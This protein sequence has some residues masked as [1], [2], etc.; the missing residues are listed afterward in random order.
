MPYDNTGRFFPSE[1]N[2]G[3]NGHFLG[4]QYTWGVPSDE[5]PSGYSRG[6]GGTPVAVLTM[7][8]ILGWP[9]VFLGGFFYFAFEFYRT[10]FT[11][12]FMFAS[13]LLR[14]IIVV[15]LGLYWFAR[16]TRSA[17][18]VKVFTFLFRVALLALAC[19]AAF[20]VLRLCAAHGLV[21]L[22]AWAVAGGGIDKWMGGR[23]RALMSMWPGIHYHLIYW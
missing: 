15:P 12:P 8:I 16:I 13:I 4:K 3:F 7:L 20:V 10:V 14:P 23:W 1:R 2:P 19:L 18:I 5:V 11:N 6:I 21:H 17:L 22:P 9:L